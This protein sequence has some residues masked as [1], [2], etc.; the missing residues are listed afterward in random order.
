MG[1]PQSAVGRPQ[2]PAA[3]LRESLV[4][5]F[6]VEDLESLCFDLGLDYDGLPG[7][8]K[9]GKVVELIE[10]FGRT[11]RIVELIDHCAQLRPN[12]AWGNLREAA[13]SDPAQFRP[14]TPVS[15][16]ATPGAQILNLPADRALKIGVAV[17]AL[18]ILLLLC[19]FSGGLLAGRFVSVTL[20]PVPV[21][22]QVGEQ[23]ASELASLQLLRPGD[24][25]ALTYNNVRATSL[26]HVLLVSPESPVS[27]IHVQFLDGG[28][29][30][31]NLRL[32]ALGNRRVVI[33]LGLVTINGRLV[34]RPRTA[35]LDLLNLG[36]TTFGWVPI[37]L[38]VV[39]YFTDYLQRQIDLA[40]RQFR[41]VRANVDDNHLDLVLRKR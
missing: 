27:E 16:T 7:D 29:V 19:G 26:A 17:G 40:S 2:S 5:Y 23:A 21:I 18:A 33:G 31:L 39:S 37:P 11:G 8:G 12:L 32:R 35:A 22:P 14:L 25:K 30:A 24:E 9:R 1:N 6:E 38:N 20:N 28:D 15:T 10:Y 4:D 41:F 36:G 34:L 13:V 3:L